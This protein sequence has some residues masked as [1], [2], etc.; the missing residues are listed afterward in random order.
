MNPLPHHLASATPISCLSFPAARF[1]G[2]TPARFVLAPSSPLPS[3]F[4]SQWICP[5][6]S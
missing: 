1:L 6:L 4:R 5:S 2:F 3:S